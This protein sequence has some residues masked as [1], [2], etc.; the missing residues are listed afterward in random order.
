MSRERPPPAP[1]RPPNQAE[2]KQASAKLDAHAAREGRRR[3]EAEQLKQF[4]GPG[5]IGYLG[6]TFSRGRLQR[7]P[8]FIR[9]GYEA[10]IVDELRA[11]FIQ[12]PW[13]PAR[14]RSGMTTKERQKMLRRAEQAG[15]IRRVGR[16]RFELVG[17]SPDA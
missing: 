8:Q 16:G 1:S 14:C 15:Q 4:S 5:F 2:I 7:A 13:R 6:A 12:R 3:A 11:F 10:S 9:R 17:V